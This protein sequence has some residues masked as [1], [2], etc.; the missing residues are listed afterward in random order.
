MADRIIAQ[1][2]MTPGD[3]RR[4]QPPLGHAIGEAPRHICYTVGCGGS[5]IWRRRLDFV[6]KHRPHLDLS[7]AHFSTDAARR[8]AQ[9]AII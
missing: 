4:I 2:P 5:I 3:L 9:V 6:P 8:K 1:P 7:S